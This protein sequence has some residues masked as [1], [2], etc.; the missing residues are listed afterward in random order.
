MTD[1]TLYKEGQRCLNMEFK[2]GNTSTKRLKRKHI[3]KDIQ[4]LVFEDVNGF[5]FHILEKANGTG[6]ET[7]W[8]TIQHEL[9]AVT[10]LDRKFNTKH[11]TFHCCV[12]R[13]AYSVQTTF[14]LNDDS[15][16]MDWLNNL[17]PPVVNV[18][19]SLLID[20]PDTDGWVARGYSS[21][22][23]AVTMEVR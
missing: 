19:K 10:Q 21:N 13:E 23:E 1:L 20:L 11:F 6:I 18:K 16:K 2:A 9:K 4:K 3:N 7:L 22:V 12:L 8:K 14:V 5:W 15:R 17:Q